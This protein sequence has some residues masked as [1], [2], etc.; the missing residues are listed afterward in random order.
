MILK[1]VVPVVHAAQDKG[2]SQRSLD[3]T[4]KPSTKDIQFH[5]EKANSILLDLDGDDE[6]GLVRVPRAGNSH[7]GPHGGGGLRVAPPSQ[8]AKGKAKAK[9]Q[10][11]GKEQPVT[12][13]AAKARASTAKEFAETSILLK[14]AK[15][16]ATTLLQETTPKLLGGDQQCDEDASLALVRNRLELVDLALNRADGPE[17]IGA[18]KRFFAKA[19]E[20]PYIRELQT[21]IFSSEDGVLTIG[22]ATSQRE[23]LM[24]L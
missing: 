1:R 24:D 7:S 16:A 13:L 14:S 3:Q 8:R 11:R 18:S 19:V 22:M 20:D 2:V 9:S 21:T 6:V 10:S 15:A 17:G 5:T 4:A 12:L 23:T